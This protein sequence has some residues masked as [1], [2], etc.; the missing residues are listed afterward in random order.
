MKIECKCGCR[1]GNYLEILPFLDGLP[2]YEATIKASWRKYLL[3]RFKTAFFYLIG[4][5]DILLKDGI[6]LSVKDCEEIG[7]F[8]GNK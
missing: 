3:K 5:E 4:R 7:K 8:G 6:Y 1:C 2:Y